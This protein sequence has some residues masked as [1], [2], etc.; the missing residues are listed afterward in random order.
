VDFEF[1]KDP[2]TKK[3]VNKFMFVHNNQKVFE[4][5][6]A[7]THQG[8]LM[9][10]LQTLPIMI[11]QGQLVDILT[12]PSLLNMLLS[13]VV[14]NSIDQ[15][16]LTLYDDLSINAKI[17]DVGKAI[18][19]QKQAKAARRQYAS[20]AEIAP[21]AQQINE[22]LSASLECKGVNQ[23]IPVTIKTAPFGVDYLLMPA[24]KFADEQDYVLLTDL[25][26]KESLIY[27]LNIIDHGT[28]N[29]T[30]GIVAI[31]QVLAVMRTLLAGSTAQQ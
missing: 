10:F 9:S 2:T 17:S 3:F 14:G 28:P 15:L 22:V 11:A 30:Q 29:A 8:N 27:T 16:K 24:L 4:I 19:I 21:F 6:A 25:L 13:T 31:S 20:E 18:A 23:K 12:N 26:E 5:D 1:A 7:N